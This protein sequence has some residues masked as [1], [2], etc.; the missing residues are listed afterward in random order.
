MVES[1]RYDNM[2]YH[3]RDLPQV[4]SSYNLLDNRVGQNRKYQTQALVCLGWQRSLRVCKSGCVFTCRCG[5]KV[6]SVPRKKT[7]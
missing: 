6:Q 4:S 2:D 5:N 1:A 7:E 3:D